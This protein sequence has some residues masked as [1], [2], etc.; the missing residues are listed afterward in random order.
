MFQH[1]L[2][3]EGG[4]CVVGPSEPYISPCGLFKGTISF[5]RMSVSVLFMKHLCLLYNQ[6]RQGNLAF[7]H[8]GPLSIKRGIRHFWYVRTF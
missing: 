1:Q 5:L 3:A 6:K 7:Y 2:C 4:D 8:M